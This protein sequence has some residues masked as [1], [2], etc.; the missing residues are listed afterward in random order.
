MIKRKPYHCLVALLCAFCFI[1]GLNAAPPSASA[2]DLGGSL[3]TVLK[4]GGIAL[5]VS[6]FGDQ[7]DSFINTLLGQKGLQQE[8]KT[9][10]VPVVRIGAGTAVGAVQIVGPEQQVRKVQAVAE[11]ELSLGNSMR[12]RALVPI[13][14]RRADTSTI[15]GVGG[16]GVSANIKFPL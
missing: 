8:G 11:L 16:V 7:I 10:V 2:L 4:I 12:A 1:V 5:V 9:K 14:T 15:R 6:H 13:T 3:A